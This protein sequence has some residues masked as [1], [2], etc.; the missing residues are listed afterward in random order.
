MFRAT[1]EV[2]AADLGPTR[3]A[4]MARNRDGFGQAEQAAAVNQSTEAKSAGHAPRISPELIKQIVD[5]IRVRVDK[6]GM[7]EFEIE[8]SH[9]VLAGGRLRI[10]VDEKRQVTA[11]FQVHDQNIKRLVQASEGPTSRKRSSK[12][13]SR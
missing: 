12:R 11:K 1:G 7:S 5:Q 8:L 6:E 13:A 3:A 2:E 4:K 10:S 9:D